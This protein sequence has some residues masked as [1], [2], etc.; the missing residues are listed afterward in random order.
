MSYLLDT[1]VVSE[2]RKPERRA[3]R[4]VRAWTAARRPTD[5]YLS[6]ITVLE[7]EL[8]ITRL[9]R[10]NQEQ[11]DRLQSWLEGDVLEAFAGRI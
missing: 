2:L 9:S 7:I 5:L 10:R 6:A 1:N 8:G 11:A 3:D 4:A